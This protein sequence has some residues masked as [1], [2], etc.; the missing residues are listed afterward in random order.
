MLYFDHIKEVCQSLKHTT[1]VKMEGG[2]HSFKTLKSTGITHKAAIERLP[3]KP[4]SL[5]PDFDKNPLNENADRVNYPV[6]EK[7]LT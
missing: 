3:K 2:D 5:L 7:K 1:L 4:P 6:G